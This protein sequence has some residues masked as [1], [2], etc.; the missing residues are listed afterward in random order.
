MCSDSDAI[1]FANRVTV[2]KLTLFVGRMKQK[3]I[4]LL[5]GLT[6]AVLAIYYPVLQSA[7][8]YT[9]DANLL[10]LARNNIALTSLSQGRFITYRLFDIFFNAAG[11]VHRVTY[12]RI[13]SLTG[14]VLCL[15]IWYYVI[16]QVIEQNNLPTKI[17]PLAMFFLIC[18]PPFAITIGWACCFQL[19][20]AC[21]GGL[22]SGYV[23]YLAL[24][25]RSATGHVHVG[26]FTASLLAGLVSLFTYQS[27]FGCFIIP[28]FISFLSRKKFD[29]NSFAAFAGYLVICAIY[30]VLFKYSLVLYKVD[31]IS[32]ATL[33]TNPFSKLLF[34]IAR[35]L[36]SA[37]Q[38]GIL[39]N[40]QGI[41][42]KLLYVAAVFSW[43]IM[44]LRQH[45]NNS[46]TDKA[47]YLL[48]IFIFLGFIY[49]PSLVVRE[50][51]ASNRTLLGLDMAVFLLM[52]ISFW[53][54]GKKQGSY[55]L[56]IIIVLLLTNAT[57]NFRLQF[58]QPVLAEFNRVKNEIGQHYTTAIDTIAIIQPTADAFVKR[59]GIH[60]SM[61]EFGVP[62][63]LPAWV[64]DPMV[65]QLLYEVT[66]SRLQAEKLVILSIPAS[67]NQIPGDF[68]PALH[69]MVIDVAALI[70][71]P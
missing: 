44:Y 6:A 45:R 20:I 68:R 28:F 18:M 59:Y 11:T 7:Y 33:A 37:F 70:A 29:T 39:L 4:F 9:D 71:Q 26:L 63:F 2:L 55:S 24:Q 49:L 46:L 51:Y 53:P 19:F 64:P 54:A 35:P 14:W 22:L 25:K 36:K 3:D 5:L 42:G 10:W 52:A 21:T 65:R 17:T 32:R 57:Y 1:L 50:N 8:L 12:I 30:Y 15:P 43:L 58:M 47:H 48:G 41:V 23:M 62:S 27:G 66:G 56:A 34:F 13:F 16:K 61:D 31:A 40:E 69:R 38:F 60:S 67:T